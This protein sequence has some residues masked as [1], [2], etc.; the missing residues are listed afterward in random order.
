MKGEG[1]CVD[2]LWAQ[3]VGEEAD[4]VVEKIRAIKHR[5]ES[6][7]WSDFAILVRSNDGAEPF[8][9]ALDQARIP[10]QFLA[11]RGLY[12]K[13]VVIDVLSLLSLLDGYH[14]SSMVWRALTLPGID[15]GG[16]DLAELLQC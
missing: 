16:K 15:L 1:G 14:E 5:S 9:Q 2:V 7:R 6:V 12:T 11:L 4:R 13:P 3:S 10:F 8:L